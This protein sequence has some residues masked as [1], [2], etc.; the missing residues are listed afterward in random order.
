MGAI[1]SFPTSGVRQVRHF[2]AW[3]GT[4]Q[5][6]IGGYAGHVD[7]RLFTNPHVALRGNLP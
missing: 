1:G 4:V 5:G 6:T 3:L 2:S 7:E